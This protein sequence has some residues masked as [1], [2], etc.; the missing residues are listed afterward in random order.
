[1]RYVLPTL[2]ALMTACAHTGYETYREASGTFS[3]DV[4]RSWKKY[5]DSD[6][7]RKPN[8]VVSWYGKIVED[9]GYPVGAIVELEK[10]NRRPDDFPPERDWEF[11]KKN[12]LEPTDRL[13]DGTHP[14]EVRVEEATMAG[15]PAR[16][17]SRSVEQLSGDGPVRGSDKKH[18]SRIEGIVIQ[19]PDAYYVLEYRA[20]NELFDKYRPAFE[21]MKESFRLN[22]DKP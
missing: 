12:I 11:Y 19:T 20:T 18:P 7:S 9:K 22:P 6:F 3:L 1:M 14:S 5:R 13:F 2:L 4:P 17:F 21:R 15:L 16:L 10:L 8:A